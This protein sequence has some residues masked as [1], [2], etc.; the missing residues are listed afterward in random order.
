MKSILTGRE[1]S[2]MEI[3]KHRSYE[4]GNIENRESKEVSRK[5]EFIKEKELWNDMGNYDPQEILDFINEIKEKKE[6]SDIY[7]ETNYDYDD[8][9]NSISIEAYGWRKETEK[10]YQDR[11]TWL[12]IHMCW[13]QLKEEK[14]RKEKE[15]E[16]QRKKV[17]NKE[18]IE[19]LKR[20]LKDLEAEEK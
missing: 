2:Q 9:M 20:E 14:D 17:Y 12:E 7:L 6:Y 8:G 15:Q 13:K 5:R 16:H 1:I 10:E 3:D 19:Q 18:R 4:F 11:L